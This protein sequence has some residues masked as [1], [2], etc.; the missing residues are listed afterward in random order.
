M[1]IGASL[2]AELDDALQHGSSDKRLA[3]L[4][5]ITDLF[6]GNSGHYE[7]EQVKLFDD[8]LLRMIGHIESKALAEFGR[9]LAPVDDAPLEVIR[10]LANHDEINVAG[11]VLTESKRL[12]APDLV[13][14]AH[15]K[16]QDHLL[17]ISRRA[18][19]DE[20][21]TDVLVDRGNSEVACS[22]AVNAGARFSQAGF[23]TLVKRAER[24][25]R[26]AELAGRRPDM[27]PQLFQQL[28]S[29]ATEAVRARLA[30]SLQ[31]EAA[32]EVGAMLNKVARD[33]SEQGGPN[34]AKAKRA[35]KLLQQDGKLDED[36]VL[37]FAMT[38]SVEEAVA[39]LAAMCS[40]PVEI[41]DQ[42]LYGD[43]IDALL[44]PCKAAGL[45]WPAA[46]AIM[47]LNRIHAAATDE[48]FESAKQTF[49]RLSVPAAQRI[50]RFWQVRASV[51]A[52]AAPGPV[53]A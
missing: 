27:P 21:V 26:L 41:I 42:L 19:I 2:L 43:R 32:G 39:A 16:G 52:G 37:N 1:A 10:R 53:S 12:S 49:Q 48:S 40:A 14:I 11:P 44:I 47:R 23:A 9:R 3:T 45:D 46:K 25:H 29:K 36:T 17:A 6:L 22:V 51:T 24:D 33:L 30:A 34:Y 13:K 7:P 8:V 38:W 50:M 18:E 20:S 15:S 4:R 35:V 31:P 5:S 28:L